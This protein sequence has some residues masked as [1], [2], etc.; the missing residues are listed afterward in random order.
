MAI[1]LTKDCPSPLICFA[2]LKTWPIAGKEK[3]ESITMITKTHF[4]LP[5]MIALVSA[6]IFVLIM[7]KFN[8]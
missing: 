7:I 3:E 2:Q 6:V 8:F 1:A 5:G 4:S